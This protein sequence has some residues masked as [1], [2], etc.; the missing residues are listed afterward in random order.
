MK[1]LGYFSLF[2][3]L[4]S[5]VDLFVFY[6]FFDD[7][8]SIIPLVLILLVMVLNATSISLTR[9]WRVIAFKKINILD[10][11]TQNSFSGKYKPVL[12]MNYTSLVLMLLFMLYIFYLAFKIVILEGI[13]NETYTSYFLL[14]CMFVF[15]VTTTLSLAF[16]YKVK[17]FKI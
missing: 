12:I 16:F 2:F 13:F 1:A 14:N 6:I 10:D 17:F 8:P 3:T 11:Y 4:L 5:I 15:M 9:F 7:V